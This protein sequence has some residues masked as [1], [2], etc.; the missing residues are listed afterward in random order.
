INAV[1]HDV[2]PTTGQLIRDL[3]RA[4]GHIFCGT[5]VHDA[6]RQ[7]AITIVRPDKGNLP[8]AN[9]ES[10]F[11]GAGATRDTEDTPNFGLLFAVNHHGVVACCAARPMPPLSR[12]VLIDT[13]IDHYAP[14]L[15]HE[16]VAEHIAV[17]VAWLIVGPH[18]SAIDEPP[19][20]QTAPSIITAGGSF[21]WL[22][23]G[24]NI[25]RL[26]SQQTRRIVEQPLRR[27]WD[28]KRG[29][30]EERDLP[31][32]EGEV[33]KKCKR[34]DRLGSQR[35]KECRW[36]DFGYGPVERDQVEHV[37]DGDRVIHGT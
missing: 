21:D 34:C 17:C 22:T 33:A 5:A 28:A 30:V 24:S 1:F 37:L 2:A 36:K 13:G 26:S 35:F 25:S 16:L 31:V 9:R 7:P 19:I 32:R 3:K 27:R 11:N 23:R 4:I 6:A 18:G 29:V 10:S 15:Q 12:L 8:G 20:P 14:T